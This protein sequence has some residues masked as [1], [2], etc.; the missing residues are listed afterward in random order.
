MGMDF[1]PTFFAHPKAADGRTL[2]HPDEQIRGFWIEHGIACRRIGAYLGKASARLVSPTSGFPT[3][4]KD[5]PSIGD[6]LRERLA[7]ALDKI[8]AEPI[9]PGFQRRGRVQ[10]FRARLRSLCRRLTR[11]LPG[12]RP[13]RKKMLCLDAGHFHP[14]EVISDKLR[15]FLTY[16]TRYCSTSAEVCAGIATMWS[17]WGGARGD[18]AGDRAATTST[19]STSA[20]TSSTPASTESRPG[21]SALG[22]CS[23][24]SS[25][26]WW[27]QP[28]GSRNTRRFDNYIARLALLEELKSLPFE[29]GLG[30]LPPEPERPGR[31][32][33]AR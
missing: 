19:G 13:L 4:S 17:P 26:R 15:P 12:L 7:R 11:V 18:R 28:E 23:G 25:S 2:S 16:L 3:V 1:N 33:L 20:S 22:T 5:T 30:P 29:R 24:L 31:Y 21:S 27:N 10:A 9:D 32:R 14:T 6:G 8:F